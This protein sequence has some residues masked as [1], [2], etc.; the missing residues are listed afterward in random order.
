MLLKVRWEMQ[1]IIPEVAGNAPRP[2]L[3]VALHNALQG[4]LGWIIYHSVVPTIDSVVSA[5][6]Y[7]NKLFGL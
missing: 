2:I 7:P 1:V 5:C 6:L 4:I 3:R